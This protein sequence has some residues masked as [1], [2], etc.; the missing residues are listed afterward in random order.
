MGRPKK[1]PMALTLAEKK[2]IDLTLK[3][4]NNV[5]YDELFKRLSVE[6]DKDETIIRAYADKL[7]PLIIDE[8]LP[9]EP[10]PKTLTP[11]QNFV[12]NV[13]TPNRESEPNKA[14]HVTVMSDVASAQIESMPAKP[15]K[16]SSKTRDCIYRQ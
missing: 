5:N 7:T 6:L 8:Q 12:R 1:E 3:T 4:S 14:R 13:L 16:G 11:Q 2:Y 15:I 10:K 9:P